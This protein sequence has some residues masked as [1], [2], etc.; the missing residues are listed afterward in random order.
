MDSVPLAEAKARLSELVR[1]AGDGEPTEI[2]VRGRP[3]ARIS[4]VDAP[5]KEIDWEGLRRF[6][7]SQP[8]Q[9]ESAGDFTRRLRD[10]ERY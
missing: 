4:A 3:V 5:K 6:V 1:R 7:E 10:A 9:Q 8:E 2:T